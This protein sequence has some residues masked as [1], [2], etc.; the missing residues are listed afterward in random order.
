MPTVCVDEGGV[1]LLHRQ[2]GERSRER[3]EKMRRS[4]EGKSKIVLIM[5]WVAIGVVI[6]AI[7]VMAF[8]L[9]K[10]NKSLKSQNKELKQKQ[11]QV[12]KEREE[13]TANSNSSN[14]EGEQT[15]HGEDK[16]SSQ[17]EMQF[18]T[19]DQKSETGTTSNQ[20]VSEGKGTVAIDPGHQGWNVDMSAKE[21]IAPGASETKA[22][23]TSGTSGNFSNLPEYQ[24]NLDVSLKLRDELE[25]RGYR[26]VMTREDNDTA[27]S[28][29]ERAQLAA[30]EGA[31]VFIR[32][33]ADGEEGGSSASGGRTMISTSEN[34]YVGELYEDSKA[35]AE[36]VLDSYCEATGFKKLSIIET[37]SMSGINW[38][39]IPVTILEMGFMSNEHDDLYMADENNQ[40]IMAE[41]IANGID[42]YF[43]THP[44]TAME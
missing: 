36:C 44:V 1:S 19:E 14:L 41:G 10:Q 31:D 37:D 43:E 6:L 27:I 5:I 15:T 39:Q 9:V 22:K 18:S 4:N 21:P 30:E 35:L 42:K 11:E 38:S 29:S 26:V 23:A 28:N 16:N 3:K 8:F 2:L 20:T 17:E 40:V 24:L 13:L 34:R 25:K 32:I 12:E 33:H 7:A